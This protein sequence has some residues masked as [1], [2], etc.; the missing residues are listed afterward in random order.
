[1][2]SQVAML[3]LE[4][5]K[6]FQ[7]SMEACWREIESGRADAWHDWAPQILRMYSEICQRA[8]YIATVSR[9][10]MVTSLMQQVSEIGSQLDLCVAAQPEAPQLPLDSVERMVF[11]LAEIREGIRGGLN[12]HAHTPTMS[13]SH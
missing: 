1:M 6:C 3:T 4:Q 9:L 11:T 7:D 8:A 2:L 10:D 12:G 5:A 13:P